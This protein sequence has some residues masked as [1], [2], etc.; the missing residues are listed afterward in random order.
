[1]ELLDQSLLGLLQWVPVL[2]VLNALVL[3]KSPGSIAFLSQL[4]SIELAI[5]VQVNDLEHGWKKVLDFVVILRGLV[6]FLPQFVVL[7]IGLGQV[8]DLKVL[9]VALFI[10]LLNLL[11]VDE[12]GELL[13][14]RQVVLHFV[15]SDCERLK[16]TH[17]IRFKFI[18]ILSCKFL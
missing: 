16:G 13:H 10:V 14:L 15:R 6:Q 12:G 2:S 3:R 18:I 7:K 8:A 4:A 9:K 5:A 17:I 11:L 1:M